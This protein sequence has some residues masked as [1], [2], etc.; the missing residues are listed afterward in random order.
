M[1]AGTVSIMGTMMRLLL[2][3]IGTISLGLGV[4]GMFVPIL[5]TTPFLLLTAFC[6]GR[7]SERLHRWLINHPRLG[8]YL[9]GF[10]YGGGI[11]RRAKRAAL[12]TLWPGIALSCIIIVWRVSNPVVYI[13]V[14]VLIVAIATAVT[15]YIVTRPECVEL[16]EDAEPF[17]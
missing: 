14:P 5:P 7:S 1:L 3:L 12:L 10:L 4:F 17:C 2:I 15:V 11:P 6:Y 8:V 13:G 16:T 9:V